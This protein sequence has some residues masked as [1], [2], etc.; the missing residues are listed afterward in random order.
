MRILAVGDV[1]GAPGLQVL[2]RRLHGLQKLEQIDLT[3]VNGENANM[4]G[5]T[6][7]RPSGSLTAAPM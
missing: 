5:L 3:I 1:C 2:E 4:R 7:N 6:P